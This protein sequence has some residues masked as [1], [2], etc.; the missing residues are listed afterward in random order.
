MNTD[1]QNLL[2]IAAALD[3]QPWDSFAAVPDVDRYARALSGEAPLSD[4]EKRQLW[5]SPAAR[6]NFLEARQERIDATA[7]H[8]AAS[9]FTTEGW[10]Q[11]ADSSGA[12]TA[13]VQVT[14]FTLTV[15]RDI[16]D[17]DEPDWILVLTLSERMRT[18]LPAGS[19]VRAVDTGGVTWLEGEPDVTRIVSGL[20]S[21]DSNPV[22]RLK[23]F[24][25]RI[26]PA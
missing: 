18:S 6:T 25:I 19:R 5:R 7:A 2:L 1:K 10:R 17:P 15:Q 26:E 22:E 24:G 14:D 12:T 9:R 11:A 3:A 21:H 8:W 13:M 23:T 20:W 4:A 16:S